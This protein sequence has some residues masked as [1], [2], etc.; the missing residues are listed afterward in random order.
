MSIAI[1]IRQDATAARDDGMGHALT[2]PCSRVGT[3]TPFVATA[4]ET[5]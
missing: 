5:S 4:K 3:R 2:C 1:L